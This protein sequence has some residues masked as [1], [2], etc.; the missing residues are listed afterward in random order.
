MRRI[1]TINGEFVKVYRK[2]IEQ[3]KKTLKFRILGGERRRR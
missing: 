3:R 2:E 1:L